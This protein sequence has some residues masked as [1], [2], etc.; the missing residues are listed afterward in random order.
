MLLALP[1]FAQDF[2]YDG[3]WCNFKNIIGTSRVDG[4]QSDTNLPVEMYD[5]DG[6]KVGNESES[7]PSG[8]YIKR[9]GKE[10]KK[11]KID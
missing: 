2:E 10:V 4:I 11:I 7:L 1:S 6:V 8:I 5:L 9:E 3:I